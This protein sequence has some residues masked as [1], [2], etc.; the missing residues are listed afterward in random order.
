MTKPTQ[1]P[2]G[3]ENAKS[4]VAFTAIMTAVAGGA[5]LV[6]AGLILGFDYLIHGDPDEREQLEKTREQRRADRY[7]DAL[8]WLDADRADRDRHRRA[9]RDWFSADPATRGEKPDSGETVGRVAARLWNGAIVGWRRFKT[10]WDDGR[11]DARDRRD[12]G[13]PGWWR[14]GTTKPRTSGHDDGKEQAGGE[15]VTATGEQ[16]DWDGL[17]PGPA[18]ASTDDGILDAEVIPDPPAVDRDLVPVGQDATPGPDPRTASYDARLADLEAEVS[19]SAGQP[20]P[21]Y[22]NGQALRDAD[23]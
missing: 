11:A 6:V 23:A 21:G 19:S 15:P 9:T 16:T 22:R 3:D 12:A 13:E 2:G 5:G 1:Q 7:A 10:G 8:S 20:R 14:P 4:A 18:P 17:T